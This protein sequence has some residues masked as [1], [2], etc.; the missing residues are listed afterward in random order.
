[1]G[2]HQR[3]VSASVTVLVTL[4]LL[5]NQVVYADPQVGDKAQNVKVI[6][7]WTMRM[8][9]KEFYATYT[10]A[11]A[12]DLKKKDNDCW[13]W[14]EQQRVLRLQVEDQTRVIEKLKGANAVYEQSRILDQKRI[15][16]LMK[17]LKDE[18]AEKNTYKYKPT[19]GWLWGVIGGGVALVA[20]GVAIGIGVAYA[21][22]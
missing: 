4:A 19:Y 13:L 17:Q 10:P 15:D 2:R 6:P 16:A 22:K 18:I 14:S 12:L 9:P 21:K 8:C 1:M 11:E 5:C 20:T 7:P 3:C